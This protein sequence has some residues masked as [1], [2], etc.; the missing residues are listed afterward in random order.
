MSPR[1]KN[2]AKPRL[3]GRRRVHDE[4]RTTSYRYM[5]ILRMV[6][7][8]GL[9]LSVLACARHPVPPAGSVSAPEGIAQPVALMPP[10]VDL[11]GSWYAGTGTEPQVPSITLHPG[12]ASNPAEWVIRQTGNV[13]E[14]WTFPESFNQGI[15]RAGPGPAR[16]NPA[17]GTISGVVV[18]LDDAGSRVAMRYDSVSSHLRGTRDGRPFWALRQVIVRSEACPGIP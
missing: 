3:S 4:R 2:C 14:A 5:M 7:F 15:A 18:T 16:V 8:A 9:V 17:R 12:C 11:T 10:A 1:P 6:G 13:I